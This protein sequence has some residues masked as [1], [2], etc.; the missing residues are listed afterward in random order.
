MLNFTSSYI[1]WCRSR[2]ATCETI[3]Q[4]LLKVGAII[5]SNTRR[6]TFLIS[7]HLVNK[8]LFYTTA[9]NLQYG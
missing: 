3:R 5:K 7:Q 4:T 2:D 8:K 6:I 9:Q 1:K